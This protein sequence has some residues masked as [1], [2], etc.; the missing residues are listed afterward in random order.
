VTAPQERQRDPGT[1]RSRVVAVGVRHPWLTAAAA[2]LVC[3]AGLVAADAVFL[4]GFGL[5]PWQVGH[6]VVE[7]LLQAPLLLLLVVAGGTLGN[8]DRVARRAAWPISAQATAD[9]ARVGWVLLAGA[10]GLAWLVAPMQ[11]AWARGRVHAGQTVWMDT[12]WPRPFQVATVSVAG[13]GGYVPPVAVTGGG[14]RLLA[15]SPD[16]YWLYVTATSETIAVPAGQV[17]L[18]LEPRRVG[19]DP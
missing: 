3:A 4:A 15:V 8:L 19:A 12:S 13:V 17:I 14:V 18:L 9:L 1:W 16:R 10:I 5:T 2:A 7:L 6:S 11:A